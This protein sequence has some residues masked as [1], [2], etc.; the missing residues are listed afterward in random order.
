MATDRKAA[1]AEGLAA[2][3]KIE[4]SFI[5]LWAA[6]ALDLLLEVLQLHALVLSPGRSPSST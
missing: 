2:A 6:G 3:K 4:A 1:Q 5:S